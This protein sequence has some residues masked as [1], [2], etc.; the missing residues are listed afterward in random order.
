MEPVGIFAH[1]RLSPQAFD[2][3]RAEHG[4]ALIDDVRYIAANQRSYPDDVISPDGYYH[5]KGN[6]L[7]VQYDATA[8]RLFYLYLL[9]LRS[10]EAMLQVPSLAV[11]QRISAYKDLPGEDYAV[12][13]ASM[14]NLLYDA[15]WAAYAITSAGWQPQDP[16]TVPDA[17]M[18]ALWDDAMRHFFDVCDRY[19]AEVGEGDWPNARLFLDPSLRAQLAEAGEVVA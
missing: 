13:S 18:Q 1:V 7:V 17:A 4:A 6:A 19:Y 14:P 5:N 2:R 16:A 12:F 10:L 9:E 15:R 3:F 11:L 8:Q